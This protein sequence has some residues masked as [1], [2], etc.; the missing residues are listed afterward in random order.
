MDL[1]IGLLKGP[2]G[3]SFLKSEVPLYRVCVREGL[4]TTRRDFVKPLTKL[5]RATLY[6]DPLPRLCEATLCG[7]PL[8]RCQVV[9]ERVSAKAPSLE[10]ECLWNL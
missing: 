5:C 10:R 6:V 4:E 9:M 1:G 7:K 8:T 2:R 3:A